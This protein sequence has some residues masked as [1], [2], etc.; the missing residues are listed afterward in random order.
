MTRPS[1]VRG[2]NAHRGFRTVPE[3]CFGAK[4]QDNIIIHGEN[5]RAL[6]ALADEYR[7]AIR[8]IYIDPPYNNQ[9]RYFH[10][11]DALSH[12][13]WTQQIVERLELLRSLLRTDGSLWISIDDGEVHYLKVAADTV[14]GRENFISTIIWQQRTTRENRKVFSNNH[15]YLLLYAKNAQTFR[16]TRNP[17]PTTR[18]VLSRYRNPDADRRGPWQSISA[19]VQGGHGTASQFYVL[20][21][22]NGQRHKPPHG[23]CWVYTK[24]RMAREVEEN[25]VWFGRDGNGAPRIKRFRS[26]SLG[27]TPETLWLASE[28]GTSDSAKKHLLSMLGEVRVFATPKPEGLVAR[29]VQIA[30]SPGELVLDAYLGSGTTAA[31]ALKMGRRFIGIEEGAQV[32]THCAERMRAVVQGEQGGISAAVS[33]HGGGGFE[34]WRLADEM[35]PEP[36]I[37]QVTNR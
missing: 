20:V 8:C 25:N 9:E 34:F 4:G 6:A 12:D 23:R 24:G 11:H 10:Y 15:E 21:A 32:V 30:T 35:R 16:R 33:W 28:I 29:V 22:P 5:T 2:L 18:A 37:S 1:A 36:I 13:R 26:K 14:F 19:N 27:L 3:L 17:L 7:A 31:V